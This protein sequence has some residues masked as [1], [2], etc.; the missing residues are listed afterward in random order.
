MDRRTRPAR[1]LIFKK[2]YQFTPVP[3]WSDKGMP[4]ESAFYVK[5]PDGSLFSSSF[6]SVQKY[7]FSQHK[8]IHYR[9]IPF[10]AT[11]AVTDKKASSG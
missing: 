8:F 5:A 2:S 9:S 4:L 1:F 11:C 7:D 10:E 3:T 6:G